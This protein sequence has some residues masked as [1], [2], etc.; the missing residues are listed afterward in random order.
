MWILTPSGLQPPAAQALPG[1][2]PHCHRQ[3]ALTPV[4]TPGF[5][6][7][8]QHAP[9]RV[10]I[11]FR[12]EACGAPRFFRY[13]VRRITDTRI[14]LATRGQELERAP[15]RYPYSHLPAAVARL[16]REAL[17]CHASDCF[18]AFASMCRRTAEAAFAEL[19]ESG[20]LRMFDGLEDIIALCELD[21]ATAQRLHAVIFG[22]G[23]PRPDPLP[24]LDADT[25]AVLLEAMKD[26]LY[27][28]FVR[29]EK[30]LRTLR[31]RRFFAA[32]GSDGPRTDRDGAGAPQG[33]AG[34]PAPPPEADSA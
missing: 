27:Q 10:G 25:A 2:C 32:Q 17:V 6:V 12:C 8:R 4:S 1:E 13:T 22:G 7:L 21:A 18:N 20:R 24:E 19:G 9:R 16:F 26:L 23:D 15:E 30:L 14:E 5:E 34:L 11:V 28:I 3:A 29:R 33:H 31:M